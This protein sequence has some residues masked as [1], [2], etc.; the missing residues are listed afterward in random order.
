MGRYSK[1]TPELGEARELLEWRPHW[2]IN[3]HE[4]GSDAGFEA[5]DLE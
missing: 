1:Y 4:V 5:V 2:K 3:V